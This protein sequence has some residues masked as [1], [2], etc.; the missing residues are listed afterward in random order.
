MAIYMEIKQV[1]TAALCQN[2]LL[3]VHKRLRCEG[4]APNTS[5][6]WSSQPGGGTLLKLLQSRGKTQGTSSEA[7]VFPVRC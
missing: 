3:Y 5:T 2:K 6:D 7:L 4:R 1:E